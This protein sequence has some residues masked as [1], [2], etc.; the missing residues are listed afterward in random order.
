MSSEKAFSSKTMNEVQAT[1]RKTWR[2]AFQKGSITLEFAKKSDAQTFRMGLYG[3]R[4]R[5][6]V[7]EIDEELLAAMSNCEVCALKG[8]AVTVRLRTQS[9]MMLVVLRELGQ[10]AATILDEELAARPGEKQT[11]ALASQSRLLSLLIQEDEEVEGPSEEPIGGWLTSPPEVERLKAV[12]PY[13]TRG[14]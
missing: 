11:A 5:I 7:S 14:E 3:E 8:N 9:E 4:K 12:N 2:R 1:Y 13:F 6:T 10:D